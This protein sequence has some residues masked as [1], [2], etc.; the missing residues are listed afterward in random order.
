MRWP[1]RPP[2][3]PIAKIAAKLAV[4]YTL[5]EILN[6]ITKETP[7]CF[8]PTLDYVV[9]KAPRFAFE[10][11]PG[12]D[13]TLTTT[14]K[15]VGEAMSLGRNF[16]EALG[17]V[18]RSLETSRAGFWTNGPADADGTAEDALERLLTPTDG[19]LYDVE[20]ALRL[21]ASVDRVAEAS[22]IDPW[23]VAQIAELLTL[24]HEVSEAAVLDV[25]LLRR[26]KHNG[27]SDRQIASLRPELAGEVGVRSLRRRLGIHPV[28]K[29]VDTCAAEFE[30]KTPYHYSSYELDPVRR[31]QRWPRRPRSP[32]C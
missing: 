32:R 31:K 21:G 23:F 8:E 24:R 15:S 17:K 27:L 14:M 29:T 5:D 25:E 10:K 12:A 7:A 28:Y 20:L 22:G 26:C 4:G 11:F 30:A 9:V 16:I 19:R 6:D 2:A 13:P 1:P 3:F 18:M